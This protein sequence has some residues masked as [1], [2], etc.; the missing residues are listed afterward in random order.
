MDEIQNNG[1]CFYV[2]PI[3]A[4][5]SDDYKK[6]EGLTNN[7]LDPVLEDFN[8]KL[9]VAHTIDNNGSITDQII[10]RL[11]NSELVI[12]NLTGL[13]ANVM[14]E[15]AVRHSYG[16]PCVVICEESTKL[17]FD[18]LAE[19]TIFFEDSIKG[20][21]ELISE[22][23]KK[24]K[25]ALEDEADNP[26]TRA[27]DKANIMNNKTT[28]TEPLRLI[29][30][31][32]NSI[33]ERIDRIENESNFEKVN[34]NDFKNNFDTTYHHVRMVRKALSDLR[35]NL[36][37]DPTVEEIANLTGMSIYDIK[38]VIDGRNYLDKLK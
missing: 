30:S 8:L 33:G 7:V 37:R 23:K 21:G 2:T 32:I 1:R 18:I 22:L 5:T 16:K 31:E 38:R 14:Y 4:K 15:L 3:G 29:L 11:V 10:E 6:L 35:E 26:V 17:P 25:T 12:V 36:D 9:E 34:I 27:V 13:N 24:I 20:T 28:E 19:R